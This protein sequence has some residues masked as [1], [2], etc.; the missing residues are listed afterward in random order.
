MV[1]LQLSMPSCMAQASALL[2]GMSTC[3][4]LTKG[5]QPN[6]CLVTQLSLLCTFMV[7]AQPCLCRLTTGLAAWE[8]TGCSCCWAPCFGGGE[9]RDAQ[10]LASLSVRDRDFPPL[11]ALPWVQE[12]MRVVWR[13]LISLHCSQASLPYDS[14]A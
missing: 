2:H 14:W 8:G 3:P 10:K 7:T 1:H 13:L 6:F 11:A 4:P 9:S 12:A 5:S